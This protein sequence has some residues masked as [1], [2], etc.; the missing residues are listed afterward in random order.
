[1]FLQ[2]AKYALTLVKKIIYSFHNDTLYGR[3]SISNSIVFKMF[4]ISTTKL[5]PSVQLSFK[6][7]NEVFAIVD[8][9]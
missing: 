9:K 1:M 5:L 6:H 7:K 4:F 2:H 3:I 8:Y